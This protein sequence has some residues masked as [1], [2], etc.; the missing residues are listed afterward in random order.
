MSLMRTLRRDLGAQVAIARNLNEGFVTRCRRYSWATLYL[1]KAFWIG[2]TA[3]G[4][5]RL[6]SRVIYEGRECY[7]TNWAGDSHPSLAGE[8]FYKQG[9]PRSEITNVVNL[10]ELWHRFESGIA[11]YMGS[12]HGIDVSRRVYPKDF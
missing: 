7:I 1:A 11:F 9:V 3:M 5:E 8:G 6:G 10:R 4:S 2:L 12:W